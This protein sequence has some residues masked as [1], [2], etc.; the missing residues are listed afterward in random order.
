MRS[1]GAGWDRIGGCGGTTSDT[2]FSL[3]FFLSFTF[4]WT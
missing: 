3:L 2:G 4:P 1:T